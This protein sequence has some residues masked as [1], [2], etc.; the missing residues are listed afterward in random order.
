MIY[1]SP[2]SRTNTTFVALPRLSAAKIVQ[3]SFLM[4]LIS[5]KWVTYGLLLFIG[6]FGFLTCF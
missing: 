3:F 2:P 4:M 5:L 6:G 1:N